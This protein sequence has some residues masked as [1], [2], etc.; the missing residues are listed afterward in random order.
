[1]ID[2]KAYRFRWNRTDE[3]G[4]SSYSVQGYKYKPT[5]DIVIDDILKDENHASMQ[6][7]KEICEFLNADP[8]IY[9]K[10]VLLHYLDEYD[11]SDK[12]N[13][14]SLNGKDVWLDKNTRVGL[15]NSTTIAKSLGNEKTTLWLG[16]NKLEI[17]CDIAIQ[18]LSSLEMYA[19]E[20]YNVTASHKAEIE[21]ISDINEL[22]N[23]DYTSNYPEKLVLTF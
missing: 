11:C 3:N 19:L 9:C 14:F 8:I 12:V 16:T 7:I 23:Y 21:A 15:M 1:M 13:S 5:I 20:C 2:K 18:L 10:K 22:L 4:F 6:E 17:N